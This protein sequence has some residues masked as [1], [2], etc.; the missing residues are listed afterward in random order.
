MAKV[1]CVAQGMSDTQEQ[2]PVPISAS[3]VGKKICIMQNGSRGDAQPI[4]ALAAHLKDVG[5]KVLIL[6]NVNSV[7]LIES[8]GVDAIGVHPNAEELL[9]DNKQIRESMAKGKMIAFLDG[10]KKTEFETFGEI[11]V[12]QYEAIKKFEPDILC[13]SILDL[14]SGQ[15][16]SGIFELPCMYLWLQP[17]VPTKYKKSPFNEPCVHFSSWMAALRIKF[18]GDKE[19]HKIIQDSLGH[20]VP[21]V[22]S[23]MW[24]NFDTF[25]NDMLSPLTPMTCGFDEQLYGKPKDWPTS[26]THDRFSFSGFWI[27]SQAEQER[28]MEKQDPAFGGTD[29]KDIKDFLEDGEPPIYMGWGSM[30]AVS[31]EHMTRLAVRTLMALGK[32]GIILGGFAQLHSRQSRT[33]SFENQPDEQGLTDFM[34]KNVLFVSTAPHEWLFPR[35]SLTVH[36]GGSGTTAAALR[37]GNPTII[38]PCFLD[39]FGNAEMVEK[40]GC[41]IRCK[42]FIKVTVKVLVSAIEKC[43]GD[44]AMHERCRAMGKRLCEVDS[45]GVTAAFIDKF[46]VDKVA[47]GQWKCD[48][49]KRRAYRVAAGRKYPKGRRWMLRH[50]CCALPSTLD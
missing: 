27:V 49:D 39:Q 40:Q 43:L 29:I 42:Q 50:M 9:R 48:Y 30:T 2:A 46:L 17:L 21:D 26:L 41:G 4:I 35:C 15:L 19:K 28:R 11:V 3:N 12:K 7:G 37:S 14:V 25:L 31:P 1:A 13:A 38:T 20:I 45:C 34:V 23:H 16:F 32:R 5:F 22:L 33:S 8:F 18:E 36:H 6:G 47:T 24:P 44:A 10:L